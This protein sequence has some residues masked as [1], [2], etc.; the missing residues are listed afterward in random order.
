M[1]I[2]VL[3]NGEWHQRRPNSYAE[4]IEPGADAPDLVG[5]PVLLATCDPRMMYRAGAVSLATVVMPR[6]DGQ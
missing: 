1:T 5:R 2:E 4:I 3:L 6:A